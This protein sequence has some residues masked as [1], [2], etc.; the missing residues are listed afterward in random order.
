MGLREYALTSALKDSRFAPISREELPKLSVSVSI[1]QNFEEAHGHLD[2][3]LGIHGIR[4]EF[5]NERGCKRTATY[6]PQVATEQGIYERLLM[7]TF[8]NLSLFSGWD[9]IQ[10]IDSLLRKGGYRAAITPETRKS[11]K[12][13][14]YRSQEIQM[15]Y[16][17]YRENLDRR[18]PYC[19]VQC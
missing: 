3:T 14:R 8:F 17:E 5:I 2:W 10:T 7:Y 9:Q 16:R 11:I 12:L 6:L 13:T 19:K 1:L 18:A 4:I 15:N